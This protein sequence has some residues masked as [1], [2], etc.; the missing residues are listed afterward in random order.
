MI[1]ECFSIINTQITLY[2]RG[3]NRAYRYIL[4]I[5]I[6]FESND[7]GRKAV[8][9]SVEELMTSKE[10]NLRKFRER[11]QTQTEFTCDANNFLVLDDQKTVIGVKCKFL[12]LLKM[13]ELKYSLFEMGE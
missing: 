3:F 12:K 4:R 5:Y 7:S 2:Y 11:V 8:R 13:I 6:F 1:D 10:T 9:Y